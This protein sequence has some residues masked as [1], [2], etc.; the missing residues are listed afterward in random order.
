MLIFYF[1]FVSFLL[2]YMRQMKTAIHEFLS[3][4]LW[5]VIHHRIVSYIMSSVSYRNVERPPIR[6]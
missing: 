6:T 1:F 3:V 2:G 5:C 4:G